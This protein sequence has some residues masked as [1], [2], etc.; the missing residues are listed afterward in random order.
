MNPTRNRIATAST[1]SAYQTTLLSRASDA[2]SNAVGVNGDDEIALTLQ[3]ERSYTASAKILTMVD[4]TESLFAAL[5]GRRVRL[6]VIF[7]EPLRLDGSSAD[8]QSA[9]RATDLVMRRIAA[10]PGS[11][12]STCGA[13]N[14]SRSACP[15]AGTSPSIIARGAKV[16]TWPSVS[17]EKLKP[18]TTPGGTITATGPSQRTRSSSS[19]IVAGPDS[20]Q[21]I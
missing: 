13:A 16:K 18:C 9:E 19:A 8:G 7:G 10:L 12:A 14:K 1:D 11:N 2:L 6:R 4:E 15:V 5:R 17:R 21:R 20:I 3:L